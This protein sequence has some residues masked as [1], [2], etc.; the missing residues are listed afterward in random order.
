L[1]IENRDSTVLNIADFVNRNA[2]PN[3]VGSLSVQKRLAVVWRQLDPSTETRSLA[4]IQ[5]AIEYVRDIKCGSNGPV[6]FVT[7]SF[8]LVGGVL[9][10][11]E[12]EN[13]ALQKTSS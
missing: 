4:S 5:E 1:A 3:E 7:G 11:L 2:D 6:V 8:H 9:A 13:Y 10:V 12:G